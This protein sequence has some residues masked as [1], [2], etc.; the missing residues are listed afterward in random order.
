MRI[1][2]Y[3]PNVKPDE[4]LPK[5]LKHLFQ[6]QD[7]VDAFRRIKLPMPILNGP[8]HP[9]GPSRQIVGH[10]LSIEITDDGR[11]FGECDLD[12][13]FESSVVPTVSCGS[14]GFPIGEVKNLFTTDTPFACCDARNTDAKTTSND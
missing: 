6:N 3:N 9:Y 5:W 11:V 12:E 4:S 10:V 14:A 2:L 1:L 8:D 7:T 13:P